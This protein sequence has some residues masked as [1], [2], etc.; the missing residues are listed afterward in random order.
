MDRTARAGYQLVTIAIV[1][2]LLV[3]SVDAMAAGGG[4][5]WESRLTSLLNSL[6]GP[7]AKVFGTAAII[8][9]GLGLAFS[10]SGGLIRKMIWVVFGLSIAFSAS[11]W[12]LGFLGY[13]GG[14]LV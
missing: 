4:M 11:S 13:G 12:G 3:F 8:L 1:L 10:D 6:T 5:P 14:A 9:T 2:L 7:V